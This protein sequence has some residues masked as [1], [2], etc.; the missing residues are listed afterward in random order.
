ML[1]LGD[2]SYEFKVGIDKDMMAGTYLLSFTKTESGNTNVYN[3]I[4]NILAVV[5]SKPNTIV[6]QKQIVIALNG[7][8]SLPVKV[9]TELPPYDDVSI[10]TT[11]DEEMVEGLVYMDTLISG[12]SLDFLW[13]NTVQYF[14]FCVKEN[15]QL[16][17]YSKGF[18]NLNLEGTNYESY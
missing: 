10:A 1:R 11:L 15:S 13:N 4:S 7:G 14:K 18:A 9:E 3:N 12:Y 2:T 6:I 8:C 16:E 17:D 5:S